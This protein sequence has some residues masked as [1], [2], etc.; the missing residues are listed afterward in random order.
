MIKADLLVR[1]IGELITLSQGP[2]RRISLENAGIVKNAA[3]AYRGGKI[4]WVGPEA[5]MPLV[6]AEHVVDAEGR[7]ATPSFV[8]SHTH[9]V[10]VGDRSW[11]LWMKLEGKSYL[12]ILESGGG[13]NYTVRMTRSASFEELEASM[14]RNIMLMLRSGTTLVEAKTGYDLTVWGEL[15]LLKVIMKN[16]INMKNKVEIIPTLLAHIVPQEYFERRKEYILMFTEELV[17]RA[18]AS[19]AVFLDVFCDKGAFSVDE[20]RHI[21]EAGLRHGLKLRLHSDELSNI[22]CSK[23]ALEYTLYSIDHLEYLPQS[24]IPYLA[25]RRTVA[26]LLPTSMLSVFSDKKPP[27]RDLIRNGVYIGLATDFNPN[28]MTPSMKTVFELSVYLYML[29][30]IHA[31]AASTVNAAYSLGLENEYGSVKPGSKSGIILWE[32]STARELG[33][34]WGF[35]NTQLVLPSI[36]SNE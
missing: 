35:E 4:I 33:Y 9:P 2:Y 14:L 22:G 21:L 36:A 19:G 32:A 31:L 34:K 6:D 27:V 28:N 10:F 13:I 20:T 7:V 15:R 26:T 3:V 1:N 23:L 25:E 24:I 17:P 5:D 29:T 16:K 12:E 11:E 30:P 18:A 8:D